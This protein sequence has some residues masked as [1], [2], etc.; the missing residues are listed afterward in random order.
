MQLNK[1]VIIKLVGILLIPT[2]FFAQN[3]TR[4][5]AASSNLS[6]GLN[7]VVTNLYTDTVT[8]RLYLSGGFTADTSCHTSCY[9][10]AYWDNVSWHYIG[11]IYGVPQRSP[12]IGYQGKIISTNFSKSYNSQSPFGYFAFYNGTSWVRT[13]SVKGLITRTKI[14]NNKLYVVGGFDTINGVKAYDIAY[15]DSLGWHAIDTTTWGNGGASGFNGGFGDIE[16]YNGSIY[17]AGNVHSYNGTIQKLAKWDGTNWSNVG[18]TMFNHAAFD[19]VIRLRTYKGEL[20]AGGYFSQNNGDPGWSI[21][22]WNGNNWSTLGSGLQDSLGN[23][24]IV[25]EMQVINGKLV[26]GGSFYFAGGVPANN[27]VEWDG[28]K[29]CS[30]GGVFDNEINALASY[31]NQIYIAGP[32]QADTVTINHIGRWVGGNYRDSC[33]LDGTNGI[34]QVVQNNLLLNIYPNPSSTILNVTFTKEKESSN[35]VKLTNT[36]GQTVFYRNIGKNEGSNEVI[37]LVG[38]AKGVY[39]LI[40]TDNQNTVTKKIIIE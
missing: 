29:F 17:I 35:T 20:Y 40:V 23:P 18:G 24:G 5:G 22:K 6:G 33:G 27:I 21:A 8:N 38:L 13:D 10:F 16:E 3:W 9:N 7:G 4:V 39:I 30:F 2:S 15:K 32:S 26:I 14:F 19:G 36:L 1:N 12:I 11:D 25:E 34:E 37:N 31:N 28:T